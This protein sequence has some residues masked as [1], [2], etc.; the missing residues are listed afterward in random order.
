M[1]AQKC[2]MQNC[3]NFT[4]ECSLH[5]QLHN[6]KE[7]RF[8]EPQT[9]LDTFKAESFTFSKAV[10][11]QHIV[12]NKSPS[13]KQKKVLSHAI[14]V[15]SE[16]EVTKFRTARL[17]S[18]KNKRR[19]TRN[20]GKEG[21]IKKGLGSNKRKAGSGSSL[22]FAVGSRAETRVKQTVSKKRVDGAKDG[23]ESFTIGERELPIPCAKS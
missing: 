18:H 11:A 20:S 13:H 21:T 1:D 16:V 2:P 14:V 23:K 17:I 7:L 15:V 9:L 8:I 5:L 19:N 3:K 6:S 4:A 12:P 10:S 22:Q